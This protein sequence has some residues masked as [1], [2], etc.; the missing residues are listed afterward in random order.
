MSE[1]EEVKRGA[2]SEYYSDLWEGK[3]KL[4]TNCCTD[5]SEKDSGSCCCSGA[6]SMSKEIKQAIAKVHDDVVSK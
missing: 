3:K 6:A 5:E 2:V 4:Q 1:E